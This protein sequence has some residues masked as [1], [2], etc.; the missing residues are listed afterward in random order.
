M[1]SEA[2]GL[3]A[4]VA[5]LV[6]PAALDLSV[7]APLTNSFRALRGRPLEVDASQVERVGAICLQVLHSACLTWAQ[8]EAPL[9]F[10][11]P[12]AALVEALSLADVRLA[13]VNDARDFA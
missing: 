9:S 2:R 4:A 5:T 13:G 10:L 1:D 6:L 11:A 3:D 7:A 12:S 8:D